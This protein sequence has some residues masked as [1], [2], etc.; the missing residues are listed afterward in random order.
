PLPKIDYQIQILDS[1][2]NHIATVLSPYPLNK[3]GTILQYSKELSDFGQCRFR[4]SAFDDLLTQYGDI[5]K[6]HEYHVRI[7]R[8]G[9]TVWQGAIIENTKWS[10]D[11][12]EIVAVDYLWYLSKK[13]VHQTSPDANGTANIYRIFNSGT[14]A[15]AV[16]AIIN[17]TI[18]DYAAYPNHVMNH[19][20]LGT[21]ENPNYPPNMED[22]SN[23]P[24]KLTGPF[25]FG[26]GITAPLLQYDFTPILTIL[27]A[28][29]IYA[30]ADFYIDNN[31]VFNFE[32]FVGND[33][34]YDVNF[35]FLKATSGSQQVGNIIDFNLPRLGQR[36]ANRLIGIATT[37]NGDILRSPQTDEA[38]ITTYGLLEGVAAFADVKDQAAL[39]ARLQAELPLVSTPDPTNA[40]VVL[41]ETAAYPLGLWDVGDLV[42]IKI[43]HKALSFDEVR[44]VVG[45]TVAVHDTGRETTTVQTNVPQPWQFGSTTG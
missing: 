32:K 44:R 3:G 6:P 28:F 27:K 21:V 22:G 39:N 30:Y 16:T 15:A 36:M 14:M 12:I 29:G 10:K 25:T 37:P 5:L 34:H 18:S 40:L 45:V 33:H 38:S 8:N 9:A 1:S 24:N 7:V 35:T 20:T 19:L 13:L 2:L 11:Y 4:I 31:L 41:N 23:P 43:T 17:E 26:N 42:T